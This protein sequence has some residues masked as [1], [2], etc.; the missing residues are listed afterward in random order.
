MRKPLIGVMCPG[1]NAPQSAVDTA[2]KLGELIAREG[3]VLLSGGRNKGAM[4]AVNQGAKKNQGQTI[5]IIPTNNNEGT[6]DYVDIA[7]VTGMGSARNNINVLSCDAL[8]II[9]DGLGAGTVSEAAMALKAQKKII[10]LNGD[11][12]ATDFFIKLDKELVSI[13]KSPVDAVEIIKKQIGLQ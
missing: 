10:L 4:N 2:F 1:N 13:A 9:L 7:I 5:G 12:F 8:V 11:E 6:S 3:W